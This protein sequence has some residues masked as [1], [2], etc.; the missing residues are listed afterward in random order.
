MPPIGFG[1]LETVV[2]FAPTFWLTALLLVPTGF[3][4]IYFAQATNQRL[5]LGT[6]AAFRGRVMALFILVFAGTMPFGAPAI[7]WLSEQFGPRVG[8][9]GGGAV[10]LLAALVALGLAVAPLWRPDPDPA[11]PT[12][13]ALR[14]I[15]AANSGDQHIP[16]ELSG[17]IA[18]PDVQSPVRVSQA[19]ARLGTMENKRLLEC[20]DAD[21]A[22]LRDVAA[23][24]DLT[25]T[26]PSCP[27]WTVADL[28]RHVGAVYLHKV[29]CMRL[30]GPPKPWPPEGLND[31]EPLALLDRAY[32]ALSAEFAARDP[33][34]QAF[35][36][37]GPDQTV[38]FWIRRMAQET[39][40]HRVDAELGAG[41]PHA[42]I[43][44]DLAI[45]GI[46]ELLVAFVEYGTK[47][48]PDEFT[49]MLGSTDGRAVRVEANG[50]A[51]LV[52]PTPEGVHVRVSDVESAEAV[53]RGD[54]TDVLLWLWNRAG[55]GT[56][57]RTGDADVLATLRRVLE[58]APSEP[59]M[60]RAAK[61][62]LRRLFVAVDPPPEA[63]GAPGRG[64]RHARGEPGER[65]R[66][67]NANGR[68]R[69]VARHAGLPRRRAGRSRRRAAA[70]VAVSP[71]RCPA[72]VRRAGRPIAIRFAGGGR[73][74]R[75]R[76]TVLWAGVD[77]DVPALRALAK[78]VRQQLQAQQAAVRR[79]AVP[80]A[81]D[82][83]PRR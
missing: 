9:W 6:D 60:R 34:S 48:W 17:T 43:P 27:D 79:Q 80:A 61:G 45:D 82:D 39:V 83:L 66:A 74:G 73:F 11:A 57:E 3:F 72:A 16:S 50:S 75:G 47:T 32:A 22:R 13:K 44:D 58:E 70:A 38:G 19:R 33:A 40:I 81:P 65:T 53:V 4:M 30:G 55:D 51:W 29:E 31:E 49:E 2:G 28:V 46:D 8:I 69:P 59:T 77:G 42:Q 23:T 18:G 5:Q 63:A 62:D 35:T 7:G 68:T 56:V 64:R 26:V 71:R 37:Y 78:D 12:A 15:P 67:L 52:R 14:G 25:A 36:W 76:F 1:A 20:L 21:F 10:S 24:A 54:P 41:V